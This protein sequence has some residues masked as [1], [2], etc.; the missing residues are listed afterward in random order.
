[1]GKN[2]LKFKIGQNRCVI[3][4]E[5]KE[6]GRDLLVII[7]GGSV[8]IGAVSIALNRKS[9]GNH[10]QHSVS[11]NLLSV[12]GH[13]EKDIAIPLAKELTS[14]TGRNCTLILGIHLDNITSDDIQTVWDNCR[15]GI[16]RI[17]N[18]LTSN[19]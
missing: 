16:K 15:A 14:G 13:R 9:T 2:L 8:H 19:N 12:P 1:M 18:K 5:I 3:S 4:F 6:I 10:Q 7:T 17:I 11:T